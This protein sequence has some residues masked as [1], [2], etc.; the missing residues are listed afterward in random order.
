MNTNPATVNNEII[1]LDLSVTKKKKVRFDHDDTRIVELNT[2]DMGII[3]RVSET[4][5]KLQELRERAANLS[6]GI[7]DDTDNI[8]DMKILGDRLKEIDKDMR[9]YIDYMFDADVS[10]KAAP[11]GSMYDPFNGTFRYDYI[12]TALIGQYE[13][14]LKEEYKKLQKQVDSHTGKYVK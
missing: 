5:P 4:I 3:G 2:S 14:N 12:I 8:E 13:N 7:A 11:S 10:S 1:D 6:V 9:S